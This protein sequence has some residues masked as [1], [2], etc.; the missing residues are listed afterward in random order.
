[1]NRLRKKC[2]IAS[3]SLHLVLLV[4]LVVSPAF[5]TK[6]DKKITPAARQAGGTETGAQTRAQA[7]TKTRA[8][9]GTKT[10]A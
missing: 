9:A 6:E 1:M 3:S 4:I 8:Q 5:R 7:G 2:F 10:R